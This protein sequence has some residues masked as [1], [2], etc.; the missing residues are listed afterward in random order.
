M[1]QRQSDSAQ[2]SRSS[3]DRA[4]LLSVAAMASMNV[5]VFAQ[6][7]QSVPQLAASTLAGL[8]LA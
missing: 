1:S 4:I 5:I 2:N 7:L 6:Q 3:L 8:G